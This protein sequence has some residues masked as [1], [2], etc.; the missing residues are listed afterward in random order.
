MNL[1]VEMIEAIEQ[2]KKQH[3]LTKRELFER[4]LRPELVK[5]GVLESQPDTANQ[6]G[7]LA[8]SEHAA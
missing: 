3:G 6:A 2:A 5:L 4:A 8:L 7:Q 1:S